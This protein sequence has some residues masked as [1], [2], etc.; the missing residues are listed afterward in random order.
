MFL[1]E[2]KYYNKKTKKYESLDSKYR[3]KSEKSMSLKIINL[4]LI[5]KNIGAYFKYFKG[6]CDKQEEAKIYD[7]KVDGEIDFLMKTKKR[8]GGSKKTEILYFILFIKKFF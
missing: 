3:A 5:K 8:K 2:K 7:S 4:E 1:L 6:K